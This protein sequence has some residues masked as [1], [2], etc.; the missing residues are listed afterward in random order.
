MRRCPGAQDKQVFGFLY[1]GAVVAAGLAALFTTD[2]ARVSVTGQQAGVLLYLGLVA[3]GLCFFL[4]D[5]GARRTNPGALAIANN[6]KIPF[7]ILCAVL[8]FGESV[9]WLKLL[10][11]GTLVA[12]SL[13]LNEWLVRRRPAA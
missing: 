6:L 12:G 13:W 9:P 3:S 11:G 4:W 5:L 7:A 10:A 2:W 8:L 1:A